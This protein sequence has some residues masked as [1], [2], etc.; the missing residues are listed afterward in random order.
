MHRETAEVGIYMY[1]YKCA[2]LNY[3]HVQ[4]TYMYSCDTCTVYI[5]VQIRISTLQHVYS[6]TLFPI[7]YIY[8]LHG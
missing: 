3:I 5:H 2:S 1:T 6:I 7:I 8:M 4:C